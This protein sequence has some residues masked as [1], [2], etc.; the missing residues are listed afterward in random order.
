MA[1]AF[2]TALKAFFTALRQHRELFDNAVGVLHSFTPAL[3]LCD[4]T[5]AFPQPSLRQRWE[6]CDS[7]ESF[8]HNFATALRALHQHWRLSSQLGTS[9][10]SLVTA[11]M[12]L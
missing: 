3:E 4:S 7:T 8:L 2:V 10:G 6:F 12:G 11:L 9:N 1:P 5:E